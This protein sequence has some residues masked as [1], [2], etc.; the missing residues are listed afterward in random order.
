MN[1]ERLQVG[2]PMGMQYH[3]FTTTSYSFQPHIPNPENERG[4]TTVKEF[5]VDRAI[6]GIITQLQRGKRKISILNLAGTFDTDA[7]EIHSSSRVG[8]KYLGLRKRYTKGRDE[9]KGDTGKR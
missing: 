2:R 3:I 5:P 8:C 9:G 4:I 7:K 6:T 1:I